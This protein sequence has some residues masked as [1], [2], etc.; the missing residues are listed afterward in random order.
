MT[1]PRW[2]KGIKYRPSQEPGRALGKFHLLICLLRTIGTSNSTK[3]MVSISSL[4]NMNI[5]WPSAWANHSLETKSPCTWPCLERKKF[6]QKSSKGINTV[7][8]LK[9]KREKKDIGLFSKSL[10]KIRT[11][12]FISCLAMA[13]PLWMRTI[14]IKDQTLKSKCLS[15]IRDNTLNTLLIGHSRMMILFAKM[16]FNTRPTIATGGAG[17]NGQDLYQT[18]LS[19]ANA[20]SKCVSNAKIILCSHYC[21]N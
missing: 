8:S 1:P 4:M 18:C 7:P 15:P 17:K 6:F 16:I 12:V 2:M 13:L 10:T 20:E 11:R 14:L 21:S 9:S 19:T 3:R 5:A